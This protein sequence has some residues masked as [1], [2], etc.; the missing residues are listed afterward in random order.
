MTGGSDDELRHTR[1]VL[2]NL[3]C[4]QKVTCSSRYGA[5][6]LYMFFYNEKS[7]LSVQSFCCSSDRFVPAVDVCLSSVLPRVTSSVYCPFRPS[8]PRVGWL[9]SGSSPYS[10]AFGILGLV[11]LLFSLRE[12]PCGVMLT[13]YC[14]FL[15]SSGGL[16]PCSSG[17][18]PSLF[19]GFGMFEDVGGIYP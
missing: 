18:V 7:L 19:P 15:S 11:R 2:R 14:R 9:F 3:K 6:L 8:R 5:R 10:C 17:P 16:M 12:F 4:G 13:S 1:F